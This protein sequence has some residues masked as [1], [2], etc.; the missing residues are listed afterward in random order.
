MTVKSPSRMKIHDQPGRLPTPCM[1]SMAAARRPPNDPAMAA[2]E[3]K[4]CLEIRN[5][6]NHIWRVDSPS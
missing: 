6:L 3:K 2:A 1:F 5:M 4:K